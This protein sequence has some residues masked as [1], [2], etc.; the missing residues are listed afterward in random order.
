MTQ[1]APLHDYEAAVARAAASRRGET[2]YPRLIILNGR[3]FRLDAPGAVPEPQSPALV[4][5][6]LEVA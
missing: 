1:A 2:L 3:W 6:L 5:Q 4:A